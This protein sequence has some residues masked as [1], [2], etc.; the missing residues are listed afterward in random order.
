MKICVID[1]E[2]DEIRLQTREEFDVNVQVIKP[3]KKK[4]NF[5][6]IFVRSVCSR[7]RY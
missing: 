2:N 7:T 5:T 4:E 6:F 1:E 3:K